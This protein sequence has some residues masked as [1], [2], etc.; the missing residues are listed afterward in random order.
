LRKVL[1]EEHPDTAQSYNNLALN[2]SAQGKYRVAEEDYRQALAILRKV[3]VQQ[4]GCQP[5]D[6]GEV[7]P[8]RGGLSPGAGH[9]PQDAGRRR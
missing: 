4:P 8:G 2:Q 6:P 5:A 1:G 3:L 7:C 9:L